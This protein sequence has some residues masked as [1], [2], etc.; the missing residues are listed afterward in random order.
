M[1]C[2]RLMFI[3]FFMSSIVKAEYRVFLIELKDNQSGNTKVFPSTLDPVQYTSL[4]PLKK[5]ETIS[6]TKTWKCTGSTAGLK[7]ICPEPDRNPASTPS[8]S[9]E[10]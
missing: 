3:L 9:P 8:K 10:N 1:P 7:K 5:T 2:T 6:Y 4:N